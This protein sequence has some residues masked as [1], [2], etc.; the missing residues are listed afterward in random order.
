[1]GWA[2]LI[3]IGWTLD[4]LQN[5]KKDIEIFRA[6]Q[7]NSDEDKIK[8]YRNRYY[9][10]WVTLYEEKQSWRY[11]IYDFSH[12][13][14]LGELSA[15]SEELGPDGNFRQYHMDA[16]IRGSRLV[17]IKHPTSGTEQ[18]GVSIFPILQ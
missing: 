10:Y 12:T 7:F 13:K 3:V 15:T 2:A 14:T 18:H 9:F 1:M 16:I 6:E 11:A 8:K 5:L 17:I 4:F